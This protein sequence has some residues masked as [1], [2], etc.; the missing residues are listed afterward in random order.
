M[1]L[2]RIIHVLG[3]FA[4]RCSY[5]ARSVSEAEWSYDPRLRFALGMGTVNNPV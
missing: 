3:A 1:A 4:A 2:D 5:Q